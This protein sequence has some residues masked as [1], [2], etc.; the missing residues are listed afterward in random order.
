MGTIAKTVSTGGCW[1]NLLI[2]SNTGRFKTEKRCLGKW[3]GS[4]TRSYRSGGGAS[5]RWASAQH[6]RHGIHRTECDCIARTTAGTV[7]DEAT[8]A[9]CPS[10]SARSSC[11]LFLLSSFILHHA[12][13]K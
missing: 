9:Q 12:L 3:R 10:N 11:R 6:L 4:T 8:T 7:A 13:G 2:W 1:S 5:R